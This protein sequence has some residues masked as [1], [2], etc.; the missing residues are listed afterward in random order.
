MGKVI[1]Y[2]DLIDELDERRMTVGLTDKELSTYE[3]L[4]EWE[5]T[6]E[7]NLF[8]E[9]NTEEYA[10]KFKTLMNSLELPIKEDK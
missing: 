4:L 2:K 8:I 10:Q 5:D 6:E 7:E 1:D 9:T 3:K